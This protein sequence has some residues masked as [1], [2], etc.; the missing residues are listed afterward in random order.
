MYTAFV[1]KWH[2]DAGVD[3]RLTFVDQRNGTSPLC[4][5]RS[6]DTLE[7]LAAHLEPVQLQLTNAIAPL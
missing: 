6:A 5:V 1:R 4:G 7:V 2:P 3:W